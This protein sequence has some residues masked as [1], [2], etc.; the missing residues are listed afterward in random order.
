MSST[1]RV[2]RLRQRIGKSHS[3][4]WNALNPDKRRAQKAVENALKAGRLVRQP[5]ERCGTTI[6][7]QAHHD[8]YSNP[9][10][11]MW[12]CQQHHKDRHR[13]LAAARDDG[14]VPAIRGNFLP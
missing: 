3:A 10:V 9:L 2:R 14:V 7:V 12:L 5:C 1:A 11:V 4:D 8:D 6:R 13:E